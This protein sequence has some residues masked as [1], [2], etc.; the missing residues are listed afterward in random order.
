MEPLQRE[1]IEKLRRKAETCGTI[2]EFHVSLAFDV[3][4]AEEGIPSEASRVEKSRGYRNTLTVETELGKELFPN[5]TVVWTTIAR[6]RM[7]E[8]FTEATEEYVKDKEEEYVCVAEQQGQH[9]GRFGKSTRRTLENV[10]AK[11]R[12]ST[13]H[14]VSSI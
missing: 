1:R 4:G 12:R 3:T 13:I 10:T 2:P 5:T 11:S 9:E 7:S 14:E 8:I 6:K